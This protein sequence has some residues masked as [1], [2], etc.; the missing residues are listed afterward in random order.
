[1]GAAVKAQLAESRR[2][3]MLSPVYA[4]QSGKLFVPHS[5][6]KMQAVE[7]LPDTRFSK[8]LNSRARGF[9]S[10]QSFYQF[11][12]IINHKYRLSVDLVIVA[13]CESLAQ[14]N[15]PTSLKT[16]GLCAFGNTGL[17]EVT[18][19]QGLETIGSNAFAGSK[20]TSVTIPASV[21]SMPTEA[22]FSCVNLTEIILEGD[23]LDYTI[24]DGFFLDKEEGTTL[25]STVPGVQG[26]LQVPDYIRHIGSRA[27]GGLK[28]VTEIIVPETVESM[29]DSTFEKSLMTRVEIRT[30]ITVLLESSFNYCENLTDIVL[31]ETL[32]EISMLS[33]DHIGA[34]ELT[35][36]SGLRSVGVAA[37]MDCKNLE[38]IIFP[39]SL[40]TLSMMAVCDCPNLTY[41]YI[42]ASVT[43]IGMNTLENWPNVVVHTPAV[44]YAATWA[45]GQGI[46]LVTE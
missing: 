46:P 16:I 15:L 26:I 17:T 30:P 38:T 29:D 12:H 42:P 6:L 7:S 37:I 28:R 20:L 40:E 2:R 3:Q 4:G 23:S 11:G 39:E 5:K 36:P 19:P 34:E 32:E 10:P 43:T 14:I 13:E 44:S 1:M 45:A 22:F 33:M 31:P 25:L 41:V 18:L 9:D 35:F 21:T 24:R 8:P 27:F